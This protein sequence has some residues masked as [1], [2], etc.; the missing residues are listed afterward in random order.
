[1]ASSGRWAVCGQPAVLQQHVL[2]PADRL[3]HHGQP[4]GAIQPC[5]VHC[6]FDAWECQL[7]CTGLPSLSGMHPSAGRCKASAYGYSSAQFTFILPVQTRDMSTL[8]VRCAVSGARLWSLQSVGAVGHHQRPE[9]RG[10]RHPADDLRR[11]GHHAPGSRSATDTHTPHTMTFCLLSEPRRLAAVPLKRREMEGCLRGSGHC[12]LVAKEEED[13]CGSGCACHMQG[14]AS[15][16][17]DAPK[18]PSGT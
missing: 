14:I 5:R 10:E 17:G 7:P 6:T 16:K 2:R 11:H 3:G 8:C 13:I 18:A 4:S 15:V 9:R 1:M 12:A